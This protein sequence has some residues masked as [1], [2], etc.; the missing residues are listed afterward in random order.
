[1]VLPSGYAV[2]SGARL[3]LHTTDVVAAPGAF[4]PLINVPAGREVL[5]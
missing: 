4:T 1:V 2:P 5:A 3:E